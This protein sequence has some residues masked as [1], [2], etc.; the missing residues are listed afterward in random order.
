MES[1]RQDIAST[2]SND[3]R[4]S[5]YVQQLVELRRLGSDERQMIIR[6]AGLTIEVKPEQGL[7]MKTELGIPWNKI[8]HLRRYDIK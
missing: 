1:F 2:S 4:D 3:R 6:E 7:A 8:R 5:V